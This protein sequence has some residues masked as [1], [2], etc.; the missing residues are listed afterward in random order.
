V[1]LLVWGQSLG[2]T[3]QWAECGERCPNGFAEH[4]LL[5]HDIIIGRALQMRNVMRGSSYV[6]YLVGMGMGS[7]VLFF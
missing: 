7:Y 3:A 1:L 4:A 2:G 6:L 5:V